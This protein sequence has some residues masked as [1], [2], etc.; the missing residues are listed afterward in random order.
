MSDLQTERQATREEVADYLR[1]FAD[2]LDGGGATDA[3]NRNRD[4]TGTETAS[5]DASAGNTPTGTDARS[6]SGSRADA[7]AETG[8]DATGD[9][10]P[11]AHPAG[12]V[13]LLVGN[14]SATINP[15]RE[16]TFGVEVG[17]DSSLMSGDAEIVEFRMHWDAN[18][19]P[20]D[21]ELR[22]E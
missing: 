6:G 1:E 2:Q 8:A 5:T 22:I 11:T 19:V 13:T 16:V 21:D 10:T 18:D 17:S 15:P 7:D 3:G 4:R 12:K 9:R 14:D 20:R